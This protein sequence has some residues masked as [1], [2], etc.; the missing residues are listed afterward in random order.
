MPNWDTIH[1]HLP[2]YFS[3]E[4]RNG[5]H[6]QIH[7]DKKNP[8]KTHKKM[9]ILGHKVWLKALLFVEVAVN[10]CPCPS[11][12]CLCT[13]RVFRKR[14]GPCYLSLHFQRSALMTAEPPAW[15]L[16]ASCMRL[17]RLS[18]SE[19]LEYCEG[20]T[21]KLEKV[22]FTCFYDMYR[23]QKVVLEFEYYHWRME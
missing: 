1:H 20:I 22:M 17:S 5:W 10:A 21:S 2:P 23:T 16:A 3:C 4:S 19:I 8:I 6:L 14:S 11:L 12:S 18:L 13:G 7:A 9:I 15:Q